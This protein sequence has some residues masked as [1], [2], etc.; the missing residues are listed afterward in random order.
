ML[1]MVVVGSVVCVLC[2]PAVI[3]ATGK[4]DP[5]Q[6]VADEFAGQSVTFLAAGFIMT[7]PILTAI[8]GFLLFRVFDIFKP[9]PIKSLEKLPKGWGILTDDLAAGVYAAVLLFVL[10][11]TAVIDYAETILSRCFDGT[12]NAISATV[13]GGIQG[14]TEFLP[15]SSSG[16]LVLLEHMFHLKPETHSM[17]LF[18]LAVH[19]ATVLAILIV[20]R[21]SIVKLLCNLTTIG[22]YGFK[23][24]TIYKKN[25]AARVTIL[26]MVS[27][28]V[29]AVIGL[30]LEDYFI[31]AR[32]SLFVI[33]SM[34]VVTATILL[35]SD[36]KRKTRVGLKHFTIYHAIII[37]LAQSLAILP[38]VSRSGATI[39]AA[40]LLGLHRRW[41]VEFSFFIGLAAILGGAAIQ[42]IRLCQNGLPTDLPIGA[43]I[44]AVVTAGA[45]GIMSLKFLI[46][47]TRKAKLRI[48]AIYC[49]LLATGVFIYLFIK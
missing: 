25:I 22:Q 5:G 40:I 8:A 35:I 31:G 42:A 13:L 28:A 30:G 38:G 29:T 17:L 19:V 11:Q 43:L 39:C 9:Q 23:P 18:D 33:A 45:V 49:Y 24:V 4:K 37:G 46:Y 34:W 1:A 6:I 32:G 21:K 10:Q 14:L 3:T 47:I 41:A 15:V 12:L 16:H 7:N 2:S 20:L 26:A 44:I 48:F 27:T 36:F